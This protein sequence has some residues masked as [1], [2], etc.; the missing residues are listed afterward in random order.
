[1]SLT[2]IPMPQDTKLYEASNNQI[3][4]PR[5]SVQTLNFS[6]ANG[7]YTNTK[8]KEYIWAIYNQK[9]S[10]FNLSF[11]NINISSTRG[12]TYYN[13]D[14]FDYGFK[15]RLINKQSPTIS[16]LP[17]ISATDSDFYGAPTNVNL[18]SLGG[19]S[20]QVNQY[21]VYF[22]NT[23][24]I[25]DLVLLRNQT[26][27]V[28][29][30]VYRVTNV[31]G[32]LLTIYDDS[33]DSYA[34]TGI[35]SINEALT[36]DQNYIFT[37]AK[38]IDRYGTAYYGLYYD[39][40][41]KYWVSQTLG[42][43]LPNC[44]Y[45]ISFSSEL[46]AFELNFSLFSAK[47]IYP[48]VGENIAINILTDGSGSLGG[49]TSGIYSI[50]RIVNAKVYFVPIYPAYVFIHQFVKIDYDMDT[51]SENALWIVN[52]QT[53]TSDN[54]LYGSVNFNFAKLELS[55][56]ILQDPTYWGIQVGGANQTPL[57]FEIYTNATANNYILNSDSF[58]FSMYIPTWASN[59]IIGHSLNINYS[60][61]E[62]TFEVNT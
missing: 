15:Y 28:E 33:S 62:Q 14:G 9:C 12:A 26:N 50:V 10:Q 40:S 4:E 42:L 37:R 56:T 19:N 45:G 25:D 51:L 57:G 8:Q 53:T 16:F 21:T 32:V 39:G 24:H 3:L 27:P 2:D 1:M 20:Y 30:K 48:K 43:N 34:T 49:K 35:A 58:S 6:E 46:T 47:N 36:Q 52:P 60:L 11:N 55:S 59:E 44:N 61:S 17:V 18:V 23:L 41:N 22:S 7:G 29:N 31:Q 38:V 54:Y 5:I 13:L